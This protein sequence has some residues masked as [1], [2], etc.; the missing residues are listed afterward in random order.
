L[1]EHATSFYKELFGHVADTSIRLNSK[2]W[3]DGEKL[4]VQDRLD[5]DRRFS[6]E[7]IK[8]VIVQMEKNKAAGP[9]GFP[10]EF[11]QHCWDI[12]KYDIMDVFD[13]L[14]EHRID[15]DRINYGII[16]LIPKPA[17]AD[18]I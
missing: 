14:F 5:M 2:I 9:D 13:D 10:I 17:D 18:V 8:D 16:T 12:I 7:E 4:N 1:L 15:L 6:L 11:Y 3:T